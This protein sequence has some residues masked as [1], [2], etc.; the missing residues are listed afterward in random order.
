CNK[1]WT[2]VKI[3][4][5]NDAHLTAASLAKQILTTALKYQFADVIVNC[6]RILRTHCANTENEKDYEIYD[7]H[8]K[9]YA[10]VLDAEIRS[11]ELYQRVIMNYYK[12]S[13]K[14]INLEEKIDT[15]CEALVGLSEVYGSPV[16]YYNMYQV[17][18]FRYEMLQDY[19][20]MLAI[21]EQAE[22]YIEENPMYY[23]SSKQATFQ[24]KK[25]SAYLHLRDFTNGRK[26]AEKALKDFAAGSD[27]WFDFME[28]Y[29]LLA[30]HTGNYAHALQIYNDTV[31]NNKFKKLASDKA[32]KWN[33][34]N[35]FLNF[36]IES[37]GKEN[38]L[39]KKQK[40][41]SFRLP[42]FLED[43]LL[44]AKDQRIFTVLQVIAQVLFL[45]EKRS[46]NNLPERIDRLKGYA[47]RQLRKEEYFR[48]IQFIR[49]LQQLAKANY[50]AE[51]LS[52]VQKYYDRLIETPFYYR[53][54]INELEVIPYEQLWK[55]IAKPS[56]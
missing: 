42:Q 53:G 25:M 14:R 34:F 55:M 41:R 37:K 36:I 16:I 21:C 44:Y 17:W 43:P 23:R 1:D 11:E 47:N 56:S 12:P 38:P 52:N 3:L 4:I 10:N 19:Q 9:Q 6:S 24:L 35:V 27:I 46:Y 28:Y 49:L 50:R 31:S 13:S 30:M 45:L 32:E 33:I 7:Q 2:L 8:I 5:S 48:V 29:F 18:A 20:A 15:Y 51:Q 40:R 22:K 54:L 39:L 26:N